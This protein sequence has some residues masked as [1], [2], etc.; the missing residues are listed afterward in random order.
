MGPS[1]SMSMVK[2]MQWNSSLTG[3][4]PRGVSVSQSV[5]RGPS[6]S[7]FITLNLK[8]FKKTKKS[9][10]K[11]FKDTENSAAA[12]AAHAEYGDLEEPAHAAHTA[13]SEV[14]M[15]PHADLKHADMTNSEA[16]K[17]EDSDGKIPR[18]WNARIAVVCLAGLYVGRH[19]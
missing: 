7:V 19:V 2:G 3:A 8:N 6:T 5:Y 18:I 16:Y 15:P 12:D 9:L 13:Y 14:E 10:A 1:G 11:M 4:R 17:S